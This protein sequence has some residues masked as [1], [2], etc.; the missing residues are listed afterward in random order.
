MDRKKKIE[1]LKGIAEGQASIYDLQG[2][3]FIVEKDGKN[4]FSDGFT[5]GKEMTDEALNLVK[6]PK[7]FIDE[8]D[9]S[10]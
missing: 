8:Q 9:L 5:I 3:V 2:H 10:F 7:V 6:C 4:Y 1:V